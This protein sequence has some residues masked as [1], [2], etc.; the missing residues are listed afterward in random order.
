MENLEGRGK[1]LYY[2]N[3]RNKIKMEENL[4]GKMT[5]FPQQ[6]SGKGKKEKE[7]LKNY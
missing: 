2:R 5:W 4:I 7:K 6:I 1:C 3:A